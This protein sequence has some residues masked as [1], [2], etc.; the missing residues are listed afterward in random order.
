MKIC[1]FPGCSRKHEGRGYCKVH[2]RQFHRTGEMW[3]IGSRGKCG[4]KSKN[5]IQNIR[6]AVSKANFKGGIHIDNSGYTRIYIYD[7]DPLKG[8]VHYLHRYLMEIHL[9]RELLSD[10]IVHHIDL[11]KLN[12]NLWNLELMTKKGHDQLHSSLR[13]MT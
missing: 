9:R 10:E 13:K 8:T 1:T 2:N 11:N 3:P 12:N 7:E 5:A 4:K 6:K